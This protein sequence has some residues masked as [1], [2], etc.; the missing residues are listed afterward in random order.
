MPNPLA[1]NALL[2]F[3]AGRHIAPEVIGRGSP[4]GRL[5]WLA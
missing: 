2:Q 1:A 3:L 5:P 4:S